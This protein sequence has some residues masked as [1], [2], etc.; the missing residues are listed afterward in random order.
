MHRGR[1]LARCRSR[2]PDGLRRT[3]TNVS[4]RARAFR[5]LFSSETTHFAPKNWTAC[6][7]TRCIPAASAL[8]LTG[9]GRLAPY[10]YN[11][12]T[13]TKLAEGR[14]PPIDSVALSHQRPQKFAHLGI[15]VPWIV[16]RFRHQRSKNGSELL[17]TTV[18]GYLNATHRHTEVL[19]DLF[20]RRPR[21]AT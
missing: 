18:Q 5:C 21:Q 9:T 2:V 16:H 17:A 8:P 12:T 13:A 20:P 19:G 1:P 14:E 6:A 11:K 7:M 4:G 15:D 10:R 3:A